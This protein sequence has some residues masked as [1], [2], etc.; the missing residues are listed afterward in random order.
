MTTASKL[1]GQSLSEYDEAQRKVED[2]A[3]S[4]EKLAE[5][6]AA[7]ASIMDKMKRIMESFAIAVS[8]IVDTIHFLLNGF[9]NLNNMLGGMLVPTLIGLGS[10]LMIVHYWTKLT[11]MWSTIM[12]TKKVIETAV[13]SGLAAATGVLAVTQSAQATSATAATP[14]TFGLATAISAVSAAVVAGG[15]FLAAFSMAIAGIGA[16]I[17]APF[18]AIAV[19]VWSLKELVIAFMEMPDAIMPALFGLI[20]FGAASMV[21]LPM[22]AMGIAMFVGILAS[23]APFMLPVAIGLM[24]LS[25]AAIVFGIAA[26]FLGQGFKLLSEG[27]KNFPIMDLVL[28][29]LALIPFGVALMLAAIPFIIGGTLVG[30]GALLLGFGLQVLASGIEGFTKRGMFQA[31]FGLTFM[32]ILFGVG[33]ILAAIPFAIGASLIAIP[34]ILLGFGL[35]ILA[36]GIEGFT[37]RGMFEAMGNLTY[38]LVA[39]GIGLIY[40]AIPFGIGATLVG[41]AALILGAGLIVLAKGLK[42]F[43]NGSMLETMF[44]LPFA[45]AFFS[46][47]LLVA[48]F[49]LMYAGAMLLIGALTTTPAL[50]LLWLGVKPWMGM[51]FEKMKGLGAALDEMTNGFFWTGF[52]LM[53]SG[54]MLLAGALYAAPALMMLALAVLPWMA[55]DWKQLTGLGWMLAELGAGLLYAGIAFLIAGYPFLLGALMISVGMLIL[56]QPLRSFAETL[57]ILAPIAGILPAIAMGLMILGWALPGFAYGILMLGIAASLPFFSTGMNTLVKGLKAFA[58]AF[59]GISE[60]KAVALGN[61]FK[62]LTLFTE[63]GGV[64]KV[65]SELAWGILQIAWALQEIPAEKSIALSIAADSFTGMMKVAMKVKPEAIE[66]V[67]T[68]ASAAADYATASQRMREP[69]KDA[70]VQAI[71]EAMG[72]GAGK[73]GAKSGQDIVLEVDGNEFARAVD[74]AINKRHSTS[75]W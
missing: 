72:G 4:Q 25:A 14:A 27:V 15:P 55:M 68:M 31:M 11:A 17:A 36:S 50:L 24:H 23:V 61:I 45:L 5:R 54:P 42:P 49:P 21:A 47:G 48:A 29:G 58:Q 57:A 46:L 16:A 41:V 34:A 51:D 7:A 69:E 66:T 60:K 75:G 12:T 38:M 1:F 33:L 6:A 28:L 73:K 26:W 62:G 2:N 44:L 30:I 19:L 3:E 39:F 71:K 65:M 67:K 52:W 40:A 22:L 18:I 13:T 43:T 64:G 32:L 20:A 56:N 37:K 74:V 10:I 8:P 63:L 9:I 35:K 53:F 59:E 70:L